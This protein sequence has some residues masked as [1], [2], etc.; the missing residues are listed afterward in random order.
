MFGSR[1]S[2]A[3]VAGLHSSA[4]RLSA[5]STTPLSA[6]KLLSTR[7]PT[8]QASR[9]QLPKLRSNF[10]TVSSRQFAQQSTRP[11]LQSQF[12]AA[13]FR[14]Q[15]F[16]RQQAR[17]ISFPTFPTIIPE[18]Y[19]WLGFI[20][21]FIVSTFFGVITI[22]GIILLHDSLTYSER[23]VDRVPTHLL[24]LHPKSGGPKNLPIVERDLAD[25]EDE[26]TAA[27]TKKPH[28]VIVGGGWGVSHILSS[29]NSL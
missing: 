5:S 4:N 6:L 12:R 27:L 2:M 1:A 18:R 7:F 20:V 14:Q 21:R 17:Q 11:S 23:H 13:A 22:G 19:K 26:E 25:Q 3:M 9:S 24:A 28:L 29:Y 15:L 16:N 10:S 8:Q